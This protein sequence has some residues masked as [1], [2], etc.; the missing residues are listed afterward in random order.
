MVSAARAVLWRTVKA[1]VKP[2]CQ[3]PLH[4]V[5]PPRPGDD[6]V[7]QFGVKRL[8]LRV[9]QR[10]PVV[11]IVKNKGIGYGVKGGFKPLPRLKRLKT[12]GLDRGFLPNLCR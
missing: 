4:D 6:H 3:R 9:E 10:E 8:V 1:G 12:A 11:R 5:R 7:G 2:K